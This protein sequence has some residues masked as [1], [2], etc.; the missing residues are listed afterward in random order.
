V[1]RGLVCRR[2][3]PLLR[4]E[5]VGLEQKA[6]ATRKKI[7]W[8]PRTLQGCQVSTE[9]IVLELCVWNASGWK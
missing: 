9:T 3:V 7:P 4:M 5:N 8:R 1:T 2:N 6:S